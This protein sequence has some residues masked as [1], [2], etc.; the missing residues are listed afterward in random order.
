[1]T[2]EENA[3]YYAARAERS[4]KMAE[5]ADDPS[6]KMIHS[7]MAEAYRRLAT[8]AATLADLGLP[9]TSES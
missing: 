5:S 4:H 7:D 1:M 6:A 3:M 2:D 8:G 9:T